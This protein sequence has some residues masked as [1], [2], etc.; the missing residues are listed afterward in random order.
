MLFEMKNLRVNFKTDHGDIH[1]VDDVSYQLDAG[2]TMGLVGESG[3]GKSVSSLAILGLLPRP[4]AVIEGGTIKFQGKDLLKMSE[5][6]L[7]E[8]RGKDISMIFQDPFM[9]L[10]PYLRVSTQMEEVLQE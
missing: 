8:I 1:A 5:R 7:R 3:S 2:E 9:S 10:N 6:E 4:P